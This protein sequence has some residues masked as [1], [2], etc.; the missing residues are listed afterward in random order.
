MI[1]RIRYAMGANRPLPYRNPTPFRCQPGDAAIVSAL[2][3][4]MGDCDSVVTGTRHAGALRFAA[5]D[6]LS[7]SPFVR[8][9]ASDTHGPH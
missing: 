3:Y 1:G 2:R 9:V 5:V 8:A 4:A 7:R 6:T